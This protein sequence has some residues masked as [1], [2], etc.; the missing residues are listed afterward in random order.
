LLEAGPSG[1]PVV[2]DA[3]IPAESMST[4]IDCNTVE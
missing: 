2:A 3:P 4:I 1:R